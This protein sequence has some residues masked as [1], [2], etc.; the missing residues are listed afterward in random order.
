MEQCRDL[1]GMWIQHPTTLLFDKDRK[2]RALA[3]PGASNTFQWTQSPESRA[4]KDSHC[5]PPQS[6]Q[7]FVFIYLSTTITS[8]CQEAEDDKAAWQEVRRG[9]DSGLCYNPPSQSSHVTSDH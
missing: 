6:P 7:G 3:A 1:L 9:G 8:A 2:M 4:R 5:R